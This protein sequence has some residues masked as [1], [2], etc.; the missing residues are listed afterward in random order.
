M[1]ITT[2]LAV[3]GEVSVDRYAPVFLMPLLQLVSILLFYRRFLVDCS[4]SLSQN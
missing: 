2:P 4:R 1:I 3:N